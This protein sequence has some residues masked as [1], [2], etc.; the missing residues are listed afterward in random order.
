M[1]DPRAPVTA[2]RVT[3]PLVA[4]PKASVPIVPE[5]PNVGV[6]VNAGVDPA[7]TCP[8]APVIEIFPVAVVMESGADAVTAG[9]P[10]DV[11]RVSVGVPA[12]ACGVMVAAPEELPSKIT[13][14]MVELAVPSVSA[15]ELMLAFALL[16]TVVPFDA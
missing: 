15:P 6:A 9:V 4:F 12:V 13:W 3:V 1:T 2:P 16:E 14:P 8:A 7:R 10:E 11:P 5:A